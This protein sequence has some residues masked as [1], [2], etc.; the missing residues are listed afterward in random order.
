MFVHA[1]PLAATRGHHPPSSLELVVRNQTPA[2][3]TAPFLI[4]FNNFNKK[5]NKNPTQHN[6][7]PTNHPLNSKSWSHKCPFTF[8]LSTLLSPLLCT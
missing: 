1:F 3:S 7:K 6:P 5:K 4:I 8:H 2:I